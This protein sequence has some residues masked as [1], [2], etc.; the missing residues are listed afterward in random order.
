MENIFYILRTTIHF[1]FTGT[2][3]LFSYLFSYWM[4]NDT[5]N[6]SRLRILYRLK[7]DKIHV[8]CQIHFTIFHETPHI[9]M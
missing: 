7:F 3:H 5:D 8:L 9:E 6:Y 4:S 1:T 2:F